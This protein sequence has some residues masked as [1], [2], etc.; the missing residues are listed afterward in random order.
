MK[1]VSILIP[2]LLAISFSVSAAPLSSEPLGAYG[3]ISAGAMLDGEFQTGMNA[4]LSTPAAGV[5]T[6]KIPPKAHTSL[7]GNLLECSAVVFGKARLSV[8]R[9]EFELSSITCVGS[10]DGE[11]YGGRGNGFIVDES[12][13]S[14]LA[15]K[16]VSKSGSYLAS[17]AR[18]SL[19]SKDGGAQ[20]ELYS[21]LSREIFPFIEIDSGVKAKLVFTNFLKLEKVVK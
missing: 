13:M 8:E 14:G 3:F 11:L 19:S 10:K 4:S 1:R 20:E 7:V 6:F 5:F 9:V 21:D 15:G 17:A 2:L 18:S 16:I 12:N